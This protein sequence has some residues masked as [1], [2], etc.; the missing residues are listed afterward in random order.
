MPLPADI[1]KAYDI[2]GVVGKTLNGSIVRDIGSARS[3]GNMAG[4]LWSSD[5]TADCPVPSL[6]PHWPMAFVPVAPA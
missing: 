4:K 2:R 5:A 1:F 3:H 6:Q